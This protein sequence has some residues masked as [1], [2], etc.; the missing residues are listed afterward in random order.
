[1][2]GSLQG[3]LMELWLNTKLPLCLI[4]HYAMKKYER[5]K[6]HLHAFLLNGVGQFHTETGLFWEKCPL[7]KLDK[8]QCPREGPNRVRNHTSR[9]SK[10]GLLTRSHN[11]AWSA[12]AHKYG[13]SLRL[14]KSSIEATFGVRLRKWI[15]V[16]RC[17][18]KHTAAAETS[19]IFVIDIIKIYTLQKTLVTY[20]A[21]CELYV[22]VV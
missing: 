22:A 18:G 16:F 9:K 12:L 2:S 5:V 3:T 10:P 1:M 21:K 6:A 20:N 13:S 14:K 8:K 15:N 19:G 7:Y 4:R 17:F 11:T